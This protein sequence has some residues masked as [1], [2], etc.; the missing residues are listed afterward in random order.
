MKGRSKLLNRAP[1][2]VAMAA[3]SA[4]LAGAQQTSCAP[5]SPCATTTIDG[6][7][8]PPP[9][10]KFEGKIGRNTAQSTPYW[11]ARVEPPKGAPNILLIMTDDS[12]FGVP[13]TFGG[14]IPTPALDRIAAMGLRYT[15]FNST[16]LCSPTRAAR[17]TGRNHHSVGFGVISEQSTGYPGYDSFITRDKATI[18]RILKDNGYRTSW[19]GKDHN[20][21][22]FQASQDGPFDQW[23]IGMGFE[24]FYGFI[25]GDPSQ[26]EPNLFRNMSPIYPYVGHPGWNLTTAQ[27]DDAIQYMKRINSLAPD[28]PFFIYYVPGGTHAPHHPTPEWI[29]K[30][31]DMHLFDKGWDNL[32]EQIFAN[33]KKMFLRQ[34]DV[35]AAYVAYTDNEIGRVIQAVDDLGKLDNT[36]IIYINGDNGTSSEGTLIG[37]PNEVAMFNQVP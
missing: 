11:P 19:V 37:T 10:P 2:V 4:Q 6:K 18:G 30:I 26:W 27:A 5:G 17:I 32:R 9:P 21:P 12:G 31:S 20:V 24:Y 1:L 25:G 14:V 34:V 28:Q 35:F 33:Q 15:N 23:P 29:K 8:L 36:L 13:S 7:Q 22:A 16:A 3:L